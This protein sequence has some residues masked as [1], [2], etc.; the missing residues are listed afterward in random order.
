MCEESNHFI[1]TVKYNTF[2]IKSNTF[3]ESRQV[4]GHTW[5]ERLDYGMIDTKW[6]IKKW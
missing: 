6:M 3:H 2:G 5:F 1:P 4:I